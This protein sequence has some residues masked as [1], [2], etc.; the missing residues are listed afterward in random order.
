MTFAAPLLS[1]SRPPARR[2]P[3]LA[4]A[5]ALF[6]AACGGTVRVP[7]GAA[8]TPPPAEAAPSPAG[9]APSTAEAA[10]APEPELGVVRTRSDGV[11]ELR[12]AATVTLRSRDG[13][14]WTRLLLSGVRS[15]EAIVVPDSANALRWSIAGESGR[16][17]PGTQGLF[18]GRFTDLG[19][20]VCATW[21]P[22]DI[23][24]WLAEQT[25]PLFVS[26]AGVDAEALRAL[27][28]PAPS[29]PSRLTPTLAVSAAAAGL[30]GDD[31]DVH[32]SITLVSNVPE[33]R[34]AGRDNALRIWI[35][36]PTGDF[37]DG[38]PTLVLRAGRQEQTLEAAYGESEG[39]RYR[40]LFHG[41]GSSLAPLA[42]A[43]TLELRVGRRVRVRL[44]ENPIG[45]L[46]E[47]RDGYERSYAALG[48]ELDA[49]EPSDPAGPGWTNDESPP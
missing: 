49:D 37:P 18:F 5:A 9:P 22:D 26:R 7:R 28:G 32:W 23:L 45:A 25:G 41:D 21:L 14:G 30:A 36:A 4:L 24:R 39:E 38:T 27:L 20:G 43:A 8:R 2:V 15:C 46:V 13:L 10:P 42:R 47:T 17:T 44:A 29:P 1:V 12:A 34:P 31:G 6:G 11:R 40:W 35:E 16:V 33:A 3:R 19:G 48:A